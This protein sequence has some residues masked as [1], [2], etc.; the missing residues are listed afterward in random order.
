LWLWAR[1]TSRPALRGL[2]IV[3]V[4]YGCA[5]VH[6]VSYGF[7][8]LLLGRY[9]PLTAADV[10]SGR[11]AVIVLGAGGFTARDWDNA[12]YSV[13]GTISA[14][15]VREAARVYDLVDPEWVIASGGRLESDEPDSPTGIAMRQALIDQGVVADRILL[16]TE[17]RNTYE[18]ATALKPLLRRIGADY[19]V[20]VTSSVH[21]RR[22]MGTFKAGGV[23]VIPAI[24]RN[25][26]L[27]SD[28]SDWWLPSESGL[29][30]AGAIAHEYVGIVEYLA[31]G[32]FKF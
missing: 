24:A 10:P 4:V 22:A 30:E 32:R 9:R 25:T 29:Q 21:M 5:S 18:E 11:V 3:A 16:M 23:S 15:R 26:S 20:L 17:A 14:E 1:P 19:A 28:W 7:E 8:Q 31:L 2:L 27:D 13:V 12:S 6:V